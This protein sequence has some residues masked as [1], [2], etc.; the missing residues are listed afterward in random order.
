ML[1]TLSLVQLCSCEEIVMVFANEQFN[2]GN[3]CTML[4]VMEQKF[5]HVSMFG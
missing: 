4:F 1:T 3:R 2:E 5:P